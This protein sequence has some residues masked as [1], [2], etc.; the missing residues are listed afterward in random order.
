MN[1]DSNTIT[2]AA[3]RIGIKAD[4]LGAVLKR[5]GSVRYGGGDYLF[6]ESTPRQW[7]GL[8]LDGEVELIRGQYGQ[9]VLIGRAQRGAILG[10][11]VM[12]DDTPHSTSAVARLGAEIWQISRSDLDAVRAEKPEIFYRIVAQVARRIGDRLR[13][14]TERLAKESGAPVLTNVRREHDS[15]GERD[16]PNHAYYGV[17]TTRALENLQ[18]S[19]VRLG[20]S[21]QFVR[22]LACR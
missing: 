3:Q 12:L 19:G 18:F 6:H 8:V 15:L 17:Q 9:S 10:E 5:G 1:L 22:A 14:A 13:T 7:L 21:E 2:D 11:G 20:H 16:V 4:E